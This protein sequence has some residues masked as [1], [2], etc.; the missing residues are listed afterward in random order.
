MH[1][2]KRT[3]WGQLFTRFWLIG[4]FCA[5]SAL[6]VQAIENQVEHSRRSIIHAHKLPQV[7]TPKESPFHG[8]G[9]NDSSLISERISAGSDNSTSLT[10]QPWPALPHT[11]HIPI[12]RLGPQFRSSIFSGLEYIFLDQGYP[13]SWEGQNQIFRWTFTQFLHRWPSETLR[14]HIHAIELPGLDHF[15]HLEFNFVETVPPVLD[16]PIQYLTKAAVQ[17]I[18]T[19]YSHWGC[20]STAVAISASLHDGTEYHLGSFWVRVNAPPW[21]DRSRQW[22]Q[23]TTF[24]HT[25]RIHGQD[26]PGTY[27][28]FLADESAPTWWTGQLWVSEDPVR[29]VH[30]VRWLRDIISEI[31]GPQPERLPGFAPN[32]RRLTLIFEYEIMCQAIIERGPSWNQALWIA[33]LET[34]AQLIS[35]FGLIEVLIEVHHEGQMVGWIG[36]KRASAHTRLMVEDSGLNVTATS[37]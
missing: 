19:F 22:P 23:F 5:R 21:F 24:P 8:L 11:V 4:L 31:A 30:V 36:L 14:P 15:V 17:F 20:K 37:M 32:V 12:D 33:S 1:A 16:P 3:V 25:Y 29:R 10:Y 13:C 2:S 9:V 27:L 6:S 34:V 28:K 26:H 18:N 35:E 7:T